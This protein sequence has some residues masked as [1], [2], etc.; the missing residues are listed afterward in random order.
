MD[1]IRII[2]PLSQKAKMASFTTA[3]LQETDIENT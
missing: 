3:H 2:E 1:Q